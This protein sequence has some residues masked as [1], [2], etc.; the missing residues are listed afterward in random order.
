M[1]RPATVTIERREQYSL[2]SRW[3]VAPG[4]SDDGLN[5]AAVWVQR[6]FHVSPQR[7]RLVAETAGLGG[8]RA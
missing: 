1:A 4:C 7:A 2:L 8:G 5:L 6:R 3:P